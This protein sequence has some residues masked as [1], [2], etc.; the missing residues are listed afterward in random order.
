M[1][2]DIKRPKKR[3]YDPKKRNSRLLTRI[4][5][6]LGVIA[7]CFAVC[8]PIINNNNVYAN[9]NFMQ[10]N[11]YTIGVPTF[12]FTTQD[13]DDYIAI[14]NPMFISLFDKVNA[15]PEITFSMPTFDSYN[16]ELYYQSFTLD[17]ISGTKYNKKGDF[18]L[19]C[20]SDNEYY[21]DA[22]Y[23]E[24]ALIGVS[25]TNIDFYLKV[26]AD[27]FFYDLDHIYGYSYGT[28]PNV[29]HVYKYLDYDGVLLAELYL[30][31]PISSRTGMEYNYTDNF[32]C[33]DRSAYVEE[34]VITEYVYI[35]EVDT[36][37]GLYESIKVG[38]SNFLN[39]SLFGD[40]VVGHLFAII[41]SLSAFAF[42]MHL[43]VK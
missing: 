19:A 30:T 39:I 13:D 1:S 18:I 20:F 29:K 23:S 26:S 16:D 27:T 37:N 42:L 22:P 14:S 32:L 38:I 28:Y 15:R 31:I 35:N 6:F 11:D 12:S 33:V 34:K 17:F 24:Q 5:A 8:L 10:N 4:L 3:V 7:V 21:A 40:F 43:L 2:E 36:F 9:T 41:L 25:L